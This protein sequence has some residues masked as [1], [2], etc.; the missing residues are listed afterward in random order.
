MTLFENGQVWQCRDGRIVE[1]IQAITNNG[2]ITIQNYYDKSIGN[3]FYDGTLSM[4]M[5]PLPQDLL[6]FLYKKIHPS[7]P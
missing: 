1:V 2:F 4:I 6:Y 5:D 7:Y 3:R